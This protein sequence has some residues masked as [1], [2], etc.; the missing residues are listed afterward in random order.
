MDVRSGRGKSDWH[1][2]EV[3][4][5]QADPTDKSAP[6]RHRVDAGGRGHCTL[7]G[8]VALDAAVA[9]AA[10]AGSGGGGGVAD[11]TPP[12]DGGSAGG[13]GGRGVF[14]AGTARAA[15]GS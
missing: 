13:G 2:T 12:G 14:P 7:D 9:L 1:L 15:G 3:S 6:H 4:S 8:A 11:R 10:A 5:V